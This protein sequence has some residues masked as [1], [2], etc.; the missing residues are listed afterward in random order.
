MDTNPYSSP[1]SDVS[2]NETN[3]GALGSVKRIHTFL[4]IVLTFITMGLYPVYWMINR[5]RAMN[6][7]D[8]TKKVSMISLGLMLLS[9]VAY[10]VVYVQAIMTIISLGAISEAQ[11]NAVMLANLPI[12]G[13]LYLGMTVFYYIW[14]YSFRKVMHQAV[15]IEKGNPLWIGGIIT[16]FFSMLYL[17]YKINQISEA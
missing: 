2:T 6:K 10:I 1:Q 11:I 12:M 4:L 14:T 9:W 3:S 7:L 5:S 8:T 16:F 13:G 15:G 17:N